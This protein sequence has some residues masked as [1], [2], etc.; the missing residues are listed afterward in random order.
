MDF[1]ELKITGLSESKNRG[2]FSSVVLAILPLPP[3]LQTFITTS[4]TLWKH[5]L[6]KIRF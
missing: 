3:S 5:L 1:L 2:F 6:K 4:S